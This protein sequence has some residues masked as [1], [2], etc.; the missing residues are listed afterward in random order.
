[1]MYGH[2]GNIFS[3]ARELGCQPEELTDMSSNI[4]PLGA[5]PGLLAHLQ[6]Y[7]HRLQSL[8]EVDG[9][10]ACADLA[11][12]LDLDPTH[13]LAGAG[14]TQFIY[15]ACKA[16][17]SQ[18]VLIVTPTYADYADACRQHGLKPDFFPTRAS[19]QFHL[20]LAELEPFLPQY[21]TLFLCT[22]NN[23]SG[24]LIPLAELAGLAHRHPRLRCIIDTSYL[25][26]AEPVLR[27][28][29]AALQKA[30]NLLVLWSGSKIFAMPGLRTGFLVAHPDM[31]THFRALAQPWSLSTLAQ[32]AM[33]FVSAN[34]K[35][36]QH[37]VEQTH[38][39]IQKEKELLQKRLHLPGTQKGNGLQL[40]PSTTSFM[41]MRLPSFLQA[42]TVRQAMLKKRILI[43]N[44]ANFH[45]LDNSYIRMALKESAANACFASILQ[46]LL[47]SAAKNA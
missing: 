5:L 25:P 14:T 47:Q 36:V 7:L 23:P 37:F 9:A 1:M 45:G 13:I 12:L 10:G 35:E 32:E 18:R 22:P 38:G 16:L 33:H 43:R 6:K 46:E 34:Q 44:C 24:Q 19:A 40:I 8:P 30:D 41:L 17:K 4:N 20:D 29:L 27:G 31:L 28:S 42:E 11:S 39:Y 15:S 2:G 21:D 3:L 26:F